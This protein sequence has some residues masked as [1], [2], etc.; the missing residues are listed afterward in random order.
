VALAVTPGTL[1][2]IRD[3]PLAA[4]APIYGRILE[5]P[6]IRA[7]STGTLP[8]AHATFVAL[9]AASRDRVQLSLVPIVEPPPDGWKAVGVEVDCG[10]GRI[11]VVI[12]APEGAPRPWTVTRWGSGLLTTDG[13]AA[14]RFLSNGRVDR[15]LVVEGMHAS[16]EAEL[17]PAV[18]GGA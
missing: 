18:H 10:A 2:V 17:A 15:H 16:E 1:A 14:L 6:V 13:R 4:Y 11:A 7:S 9:P 12:A 8:R 3:G 5:A